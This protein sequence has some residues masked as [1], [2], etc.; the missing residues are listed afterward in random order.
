MGKRERLAARL[1][2]EG[3]DTSEVDFKESEYSA[4]F[5][6]FLYKDIGYEKLTNL[7][8]GLFSSPYGATSLREY[9]ANGFEEYFLGRRDYLPKVSPKLYMKIDKIVTGEE[10][11]YI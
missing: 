4:N 2:A 5:D 1:H 11:E 8:M 10:N 3:Y 7:T 6:V 9:F